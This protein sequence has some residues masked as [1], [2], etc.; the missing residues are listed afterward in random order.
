[1]CFP[2]ERAMGFEAIANATDSNEKQRISAAGAAKASVA[3]SPPMP[4]NADLRLIVET[5]DALPQAIR[6]GILAMVSA[7]RSSLATHSGG[8]SHE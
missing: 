4:A 5:W 6:A 1:M 7:A 3:L 2:A 8:R